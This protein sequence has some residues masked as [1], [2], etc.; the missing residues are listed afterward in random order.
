MELY[1]VANDIRVILRRVYAT[2][3]GPEISSTSNIN[4]LWAS[5]NPYSV[6][7]LS[8]AAYTQKVQNFLARAKKLQESMNSDKLKALVGK[9]EKEV[10]NANEQIQ[11]IEHWAQ[12]EADNEQKELD[13]CRTE[14]KRYVQGYE[15]LTSGGAVTDPMLLRL[16]DEQ[17]ASSTE[18]DNAKRVGVGENHPLAQGMARTMHNMNLEC[19]QKDIEYDEKV[20]KFDVDLH[21]WEAK[22]AQAELSI[23]QVKELYD[24]S[25]ELGNKLTKLM[26]Y[27]K[28]IAGVDRSNTADVEK[29]RK[30]VLEMKKILQKCMVDHLAHLLECSKNVKLVF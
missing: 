1:S 24:A 14:V 19:D 16:I 11:K 12:E 22:K 8:T 21:R 15:Q 2:L 30:T 27:E 4:T 9:L 23:P 29:A 26:G 18:R 6:K 25:E 20:H 13:E 7:L 3:G 5:I 17:I 10:D 28:D